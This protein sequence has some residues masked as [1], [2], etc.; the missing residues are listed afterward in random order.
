MKPRRH[1]FLDRLVH[2]FE[3]LVGWSRAGS[4]HPTIVAIAGVTA[5]LALGWL[6]VVGTNGAAGGFVHVMYLPIVV[7]SLTLGMF[8]GLA[9]AVAAGVLAGPLMPASATAVLVEPLEHAAVRA[10]FFVLV[11]AITG[12]LAAVMRSRS[13]AA[14]DSKER[15]ADTCVRT[16]RLFARLVSERDEQTGGHCERVAANAVTVG[17]AYGLEEDALKT[18]Y[19]S[20]LLHDLGKLGVRETILRKPGRLTTEEF[21]IVKAHTAFGE[22]ILLEI[23]DSFRDI[24]FGVRSHHERWN[25]TGYPD[26]LEGRDIPLVGRILAVVDVFEALTNYRPYRGPVTAAEAR[27][28][29]L[30]GAGTQF[31]PD[32]VESFLALERAGL[33][34]RETDPPPLYDEFA[35]SV[36]AAGERN[37]TLFG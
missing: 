26:R 9:T 34:T 29:I 24:A 1:V 22:D 19:W 16:L 5:A 11:A 15:L 32:V 18:M 7:A 31:D 2:S 21:Q 17:R 8:G 36:A 10:G 13:R 12:A 3:R 37:P 35:A 14:L 6:L 4:V 28:V 33:I 27:R 25:G 30:E 23:S 20:G